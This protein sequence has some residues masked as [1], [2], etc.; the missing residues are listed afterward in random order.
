MLL[1][2]TLMTRP[3]SEKSKGVWSRDKLWMGPGTVFDLW[4]SGQIMKLR[5]NY[6]IF[7]TSCRLLATLLVATTL[8][9]LAFY[10]L[11]LRPSFVSMVIFTTSPTTTPSQD[12]KQ[13]AGHKPPSFIVPSSE[14][15]QELHHVHK[16]SS[17]P[18]T[19]PLDVKQQASQT[20][21]PSPP[22]TEQG[23][24]HTH[25]L[26]SHITPSQ[27]VKQGS[28]HTHKLPSHI[29]PSQ[30]VKQG[31]YHT[32]KL[33]SHTNPSLS[34]VKQESH[35]PANTDNSSL[36]TLL[37]GLKFNNYGLVESSDQFVMQ[38]IP[39]RYS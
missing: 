13:G 21:K 35:K 28:Y 39:C 26:P 11:W 23:S 7:P 18:N 29:T 4:P 3:L 12:V 36:A 16:P 33:P 6:I 1:Q 10:T 14:V 15:K 34:D 32:H 2:I 22:N 17:Q 5:Y 38:D 37:A 27:G 9:G 8:F 31:S 25:K 20:H 24:Y 19:S 30:D